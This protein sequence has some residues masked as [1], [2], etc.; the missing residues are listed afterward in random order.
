MN[1]FTKRIFLFTLL[2]L[3][4]IFAFAQ[5]FDS[6]RGKLSDS[7]QR[8]SITKMYVT[9]GDRFDGMMNLY[10]N[11]FVVFGEKFDKNEIGMREFRT[12]KKRG[13]LGSFAVQSVLDQQQVGKK[14]LS[15]WLNRDSNGMMNDEL[16]Q[17]RSLYNVTDK[18]VMIDEASKVSHLRDMGEML[19]NNSYVVVF[20]LKKVEKKEYVNKKT[21]KKTITYYADMAAYAFQ[22]DFTPDMLIDLYDHMWIYDTDNASVKAAKKKAYDDMTVKMKSA[23]ST[24]VRGSGASEQAAINATF[25]SILHNLE[26]NIDAWQVKTDIVT[27]HPIRAKIGTKEN[28]KNGDR[29]KV[30]AYKEAAGKTARGTDTI[31]LRKV[32]KG[33]VRAT[34]I[35]N[36][37]RVADGKTPMSRF[38]QIHGGHLEPG[39]LLQEAKDKKM[40]VSIGFGYPGVSVAYADIDYLLHI[41]NLG[42]CQY[43]ITNFGFSVDA[44][45]DVG[46]GYGIG[47]PLS[48]M[49]EL[50]PYIKA[51]LDIEAEGLADYEN[52]A[53]YSGL[54]G[55]FGTKFSFQPIHCFRLFLDLNL[56]GG[57]G[58]GFNSDSRNGI[59]IG[60][61]ARY[62]F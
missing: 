58:P 27:T 6:N 16:L 14:I 9:Y 44:T 21:G 62:S 22:L 31:V 29:Y 1:V 12:Y 15:F 11:S 30:F 56:S 3:S 7:Y 37:N 25:S 8:N 54:Y 10:M 18:E 53:N 33:F 60:A 42:V 19:I 45:F 48:R 57:F 59:G 40:A 43:F 55:Y 39:M 4:G 5:N 36:N 13:E 51:G 2:I 23:A 52:I 34:T 32:R 26:K 20:D 47:F 35:A 28:L 38:Y 61:G 24:T 46:I 50:Q 49:F 17:S 41:G